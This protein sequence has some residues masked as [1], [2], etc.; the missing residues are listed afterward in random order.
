MAKENVWS[1]GYYWLQIHIGFGSNLVLHQI[2]TI[3]SMNDK[4]FHC[5]MASSG[6]VNGLK[7]V[8]WVVC[9]SS[10]KIRDL[11]TWWMDVISVLFHECH[12]ECKSLTSNSV[13]SLNLTLVH[14]WDLDVFTVPA[15]DLVHCNICLLPFFQPFKWC[16]QCFVSI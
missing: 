10:E 13:R 6:G 8:Y 11:F 4:S 1:S 9:Y 12:V 5:M 2:F 14:W 7:R 16:K 3:P 15:D